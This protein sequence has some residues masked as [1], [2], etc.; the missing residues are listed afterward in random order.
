MKMYTLKN[1]YSTKRITYINNSVYPN[2]NGIT[3]VKKVVPIS[4]IVVYPLLIICYTN[5]PNKNTS[6]TFQAS[7]IERYEQ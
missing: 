5:Q 1:I 6:T 4:Y 2:I 7:K 3:E